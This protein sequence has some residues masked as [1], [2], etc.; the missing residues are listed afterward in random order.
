MLPFKQ[1]LLPDLMTTEEVAP[2]LR[3]KP[4]TI[5]TARCLGKSHL[6]Y[7][8]LGTRVMYKKEDLIK[9]LAGESK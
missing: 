7:I 6:P 5:R 1:E 9:Y 3:L 4:G 2:F 8:K